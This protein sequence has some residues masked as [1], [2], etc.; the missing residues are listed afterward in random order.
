[1][2]KINL[3]I[4][5]DHDVVRILFRDDTIVESDEDE[6]GVIFDYDAGGLVIGME[7]LNASTKFG[8][9]TEFEASLQRKPSKK[10]K[11]ANVAVADYRPCYV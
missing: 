6:N 5:R 7:F 2:T 4:D 1:M 3:R 11:A 8:D 10:L 9:L